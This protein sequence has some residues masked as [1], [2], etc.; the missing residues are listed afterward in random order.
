MVFFDIY[1]VSSKVEEYDIEV[2]RSDD[3]AIPERAFYNLALLKINMLGKK[4]P[5]SDLRRV[6]VIF[7]T[8]HDVI[9]GDGLTLYTADFRVNETG[10]LLGVT[11]VFFMSITKYKTRQRSWDA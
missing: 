11:C 1:A 2:Q 10:R 4:R 5:Y 6:V 9:I 8:E 7:I 3:E